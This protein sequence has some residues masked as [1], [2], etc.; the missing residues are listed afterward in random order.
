MPSLSLNVPWHARCSQNV[1]E[2]DIMEITTINT[3]VRSSYINWAFAAFWVA[4]AGFLYSGIIYL[5]G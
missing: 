4:Y 3:Q 1:D 5:I 2:G